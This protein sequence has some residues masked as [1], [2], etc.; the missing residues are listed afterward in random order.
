LLFS[1]G[2]IVLTTLTGCS[3]FEREWRQCQNYA[4]PERELAGCWEGEWRSELN[5]RAGRLRAIITKDG[6]H[7]YRARFKAKYAGVIP[8]EFDVPLEV[9]E[10][11]QQCSFQGQ[12]DLGRFIG[13]VCDFSGHADDAKFQATYTTD[14]ADH[15]SFE[16]KKVQENSQRCVAGMCVPKQPL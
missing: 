16:L 14:K 3:S 10:D 7:S 12:E 6:E 11:G 15:G 1:I 2:L 4:Y 9:S 8:Y 13:G 5:E